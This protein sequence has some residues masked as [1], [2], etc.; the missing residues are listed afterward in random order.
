[1]LHIHYL[2]WVTVILGV[3]C[4]SACLAISIDCFCCYISFQECI[5]NNLERYRYVFLQRKGQVYLLSSSIKIMSFS[6]A[7]V[8]PLKR[9]G[10][11][12]LL[13]ALLSNTPVGMRVSLVFFVLV[14]ELWLREPEQAMIVLLL[15][16]LWAINS[17]GSDPTAL[18]FC[19]HAWP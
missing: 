4:I 1:M 7:N 2:C 9:F 18:C 6:R 16:L 10:F 11:P 13:V 5:A 12:K 3:S 8:R 19:Q 14:W 15:V 17:P